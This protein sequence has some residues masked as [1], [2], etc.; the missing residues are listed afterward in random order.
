[1]SLAASFRLIG[2]LLSL[3]SSSSSTS[4]SE[5]DFIELVYD[6]MTDFVDSESNDECACAILHFL[7]MALSSLYNSLSGK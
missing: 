2:E 7:S 1:M 5:E 3:C 4:N 6:R